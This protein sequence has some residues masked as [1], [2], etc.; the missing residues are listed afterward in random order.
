L[1]NDKSGGLV[2]QQS[3]G[4]L[5]TLREYIDAN[6][7]QTYAPSDLENLLKQAKYHRVMIIADKAGMG[8][9]TVP[10]HLSKL[11]K[12]MYPENWLVKIDFNDYTE[13]LM[14]QKG[15]KIDKRRLLEIVSNEVLK[16]ESLLEKE[17][18]KKSFEGNEISKVV[19]MVDGFDEICR[20]YKETVLDMLQVLKQTSLEQLSDHT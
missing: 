6:K 7:S 19:V 4:V 8:K 12:Q 5:K 18:F 17:L 10:T 13:L 15:K 9:T 3:Q 16:L 20:K 1:E 11:V 14:A 2:W